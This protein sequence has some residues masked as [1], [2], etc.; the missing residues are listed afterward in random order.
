MGVWSL[1][2]AGLGHFQTFAVGLVELSQCM[3]ICNCGPLQD[4]LA[5]A[6]IRFLTTLAR[7][8]HSGLFQDDAVLQQACPPC[9]SPP[10]SSTSNMSR[11]MPP[12]GKACSFQQASAAQDIHT[13]AAAQAAG[14]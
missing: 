13:S 14:L 2:G 9:P 12:H 4:N 5:M 6:A 10:A 11:T 7:S 8:V 3:L 1:R